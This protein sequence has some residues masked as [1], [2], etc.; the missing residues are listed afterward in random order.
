MERPPSK[1]CY[2]TKH[3]PLPHGSFSVDRDVRDMPANHTCTWVRAHGH[4]R[5][6]ASLV[7]RAQLLMRQL[8]QTIRPS[9]AATVCLTVLAMPSVFDNATMP[10]LSRYLQ[11]FDVSP[12]RPS[13][14]RVSGAGV[15]CWTSFTRHR[16]SNAVWRTLSRGDPAEGQ[17]CFAG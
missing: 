15:A 4:L 13:L 6:R 14:R 11:V 9:G 10:G 2:G 7:R 3:L 5:A 12:T 8:A 16:C 17:P 1:L